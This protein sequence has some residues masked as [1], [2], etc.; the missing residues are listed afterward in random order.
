M[1]A[2]LSTTESVDHRP[3]Y[4]RRLRVEAGPCAV[5]AQLEDDYHCMSVTIAHDGDVVTGITPVMHREPWT[6]CPGAI[7]KLRETFTGFPLAEVTARRDKQQNCTHLHDLAV[8]AANRAGTTGGTVFDIFASDPEHGCRVLE[9]RRDGALLMRWIEQDGLIVEPEGAAGRSLLTLRDWIAAL[10]VEEREAARLLQWG[11]IVAH[12]RTLPP[13]ALDSA[14]GMPANC[15]S[16]QPER[17]G[18]AKRIGAILDFSA[19]GR[20]PLEGIGVDEIERVR[21]D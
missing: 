5:V 9:I 21:G 3:G 11:A 4:R 10:P 19:G 1:N 7:I 14:A 8:L 2:A 6:T 12:G 16:F 17:I 15:Y 13:G 20:E 18:Q